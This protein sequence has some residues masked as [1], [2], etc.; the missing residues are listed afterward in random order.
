MPAAAPEAVFAALQEQL[1]REGLFRGKNW[2]TGPEPFPLTS[3]QVEELRSIGRAL[4]KFLETADACYHDA[5]PELAFFRSVLDR[6]KPEWLLRCHDAEA[7]RPQLPWVLRPDL[8]WTEAGFRITEIDGVPG[9]IGMTDFLNQFYAELGFDVL[10]GPRTL[11]EAFAARDVAVVISRE[12]SDYRP[13]MEWMLR[14]ATG[15][16]D[17][18]TI[19]EED[20]TAEGAEAL[21]GRTVYRFF[22]LWDEDLGPGAHALCELAA[23]GELTL[24]AP[25]KAYFEEKLLLAL[26]RDPLLH[27][28]WQAALGPEAAEVLDRLIPFG[29]VLDPEPLPPHA[30]YP[31]LEI[32]EWAELKQFSQEQRRLV[33]KVSGFSP[34][35]WGARGVHVGHDLSKAEWAARIDEALAAFPRQPHLLQEFAASTRVE[36]RYFAADGTVQVEPGVVRLSPYYLLGNGAA[37][38]HGVLATVCPPDKKKIHGMTEATLLPCR[39]IPTDGNA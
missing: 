18:L 20:L 31:K 29:W 39:E 19:R 21:R 35:A 1:P 12:A 5:D 9:G 7:L 8:L 25:P 33:L 16:T 23:R 2:R 27:P 30:V 4:A 15:R 36:N 10:R 37:E 11:G 14:Q 24:T 6:G 13:E 34:Q 22:E 38:L 26:Y 28:R 3:R 17:D 32:W